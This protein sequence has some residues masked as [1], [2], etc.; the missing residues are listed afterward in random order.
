[1]KVR[2]IDYLTAA[3]ELS[4]L[5][6]SR[7]AAA[8][9]AAANGATVLERRRNLLGYFTMAVGGFSR[10]SNVNLLRVRVKH[11]PRSARQDFDFPKRCQRQRHPFAMKYN[12]NQH[13]LITKQQQLQLQQQ[14][15]ADGGGV[16]VGVG[17]VWMTFYL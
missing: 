16:G 3:I 17:G 10:M 9:A 13:S 15:Q 4:C 5:Q 11:A 8:A 12:L 1:M 6:L 14:Q 2:E 7:D